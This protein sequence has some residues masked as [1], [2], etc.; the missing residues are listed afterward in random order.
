MI[1]YLMKIINQR[2]EK[3]IEAIDSMEFSYLFLTGVGKADCLGLYQ[4]TIT[5]FGTSH[6]GTEGLRGKNE[7]IR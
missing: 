5:K 2:I 7:R 6:S 1:L 4:M 3:I